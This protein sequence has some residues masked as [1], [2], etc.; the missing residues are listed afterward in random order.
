MNGTLVKL[1][2]V[3][4]MIAIAMIGV[5]HSTVGPYRHPD[6]HPAYA[7]SSRS[8]HPYHDPHYDPITTVI[9]V[10]VLE[11][12]SEEVSQIILNFVCY[13]NNFLMHGSYHFCR[14]LLTC[15]CWRYHKFVRRILRQLFQ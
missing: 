6:D 10:P 12:D 8:P 3:V 13:K 14:S 5:S 1:V 9:G 11:V 7:P 15:Q 2:V 4:A